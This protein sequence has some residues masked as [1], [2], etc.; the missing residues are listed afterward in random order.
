MEKITNGDKDIAVELEIDDRL[1]CTVKRESYITLKDHKP[2]FMN[3]PKC[4]VLNPCKSELGKVSKKMLSEIVSD[5][6]VKSQL[7]QWKNSDSV[8]DWFSHLNN[9]SKLVFVQFDVVNMYG[10]I[11]P[12]L[13]ENSLTY[14]TRFVPIPE[15]TRLSILQ[16]A[17]SYLI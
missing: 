3:N 7:Q 17:Q 9:K 16:A 13:L 2:N 14:A 5:V 1:Y 10:S 15:L 8:I 12:V 11:S 4:R 6:K